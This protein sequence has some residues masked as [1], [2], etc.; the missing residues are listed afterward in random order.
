MA[1]ATSAERLRNEVNGQQSEEEEE[2]EEEEDEED[3]AADQTLRA[4]YESLAVQNPNSE[5]AR[6]WVAKHAVDI[7]PDSEERGRYQE[8]GSDLQV[9]G[10][11]AVA[12]A[13]LGGRPGFRLPSRR[14]TTDDHPDHQ[15]KPTDASTRSQSQCREEGVGAGATKPSNARIGR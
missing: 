10:V 8:N 15:W 6:A 2:E 13:E 3:G 14:L 5:L 9:P 7:T 11:R 12:G 1:P 4:F